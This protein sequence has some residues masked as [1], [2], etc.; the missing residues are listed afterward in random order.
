MLPVSRKH[1][2]LYPESDPSTRT[3]FFPRPGFRN[4]LR[5]PDDVALMMP[6]A[7]TVR[8]AA[9][10]CSKKSD[11]SAAS[12]SRVFVLLQKLP[13]FMQASLKVGRHQGLYKL[14]S[15]IAL[16][17]VDCVGRLLARVGLVHIRQ[18]P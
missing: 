11:S 9:W 14:A 16:E 1:G 5:T 18:C 4:F 6:L 12:L 17:L 13:R 15:F 7:E 10:C 3:A 8:A 2:V